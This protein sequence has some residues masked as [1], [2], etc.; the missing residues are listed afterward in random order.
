MPDQ[1]TAPGFEQ[2]PRVEVGPL[3]PYDQ[4]PGTR[5]EIIHA[6]NATLA[7]RNDFKNMYP[8]L[9]AGDSQVDPAQL[10]ASGLQRRR[11]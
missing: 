3:S 10:V 7:G 1:T 5:K 6:E 9:V 4:A 2:E 8:E 11:E